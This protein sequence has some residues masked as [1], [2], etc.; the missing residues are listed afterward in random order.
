[1]SCDNDLCNSSGVGT[2]IFSFLTKFQNLLKLLEIT[3]R[4]W[5]L[6]RLGA[7]ST[8]RDVC[9]TSRE[10]KESSFSVVGK[11]LSCKLAS[12]VFSTFF[13]YLMRG[14]TDQSAFTFPCL[15]TSR[16]KGSALM[17]APGWVCGTPLCMDSADVCSTRISE[18]APESKGAAACW[19]TLLSDSPV[20]SSSSAGGSMTL[21]LIGSGISRPLVPDGEGHGPS[22]SCGLLGLG[23]SE[24][25]VDVS[26]QPEEHRDE[27]SPS[28]AMSRDEDLDDLPEEPPLDDPPREDAEAP[29][30]AATPTPL[31]R[32][33]PTLCEGVSLGRGGDTAAAAPL[34]LN[35]AGVLT[36]PSG[37]WTDPHTSAHFLPAV[38][39]CLWG[40]ASVSTGPLGAAAISGTA[41]SRATRRPPPTPL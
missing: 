31:G 36:E 25:F 13:K 30:P 6:T 35:T 20:W 40:A 41:V 21:V 16:P 26:Q 28:R 5:L 24:E 38:P 29:P 7:R 17:K 34:C 2:L 9:P 22:G 18:V 12:T 14:S 19:S 4:K 27:M 10:T 11:R 39:I 1:M 33:T 37:C 23:G 32:L 15:G 8:I 3:A